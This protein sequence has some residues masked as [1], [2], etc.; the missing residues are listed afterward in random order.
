MGTSVKYRLRARTTRIIVH[1]SHTHLPWGPAQIDED[2]QKLGLVTVG[3]HFVLPREGG[4]V[5]YRPVDCI[6]AHTP[7]HNDDSIGVCWEGGR[8][9]R[10]NACPN[11]TFH[12]RKALIHL[13]A[14]L[15]DLHGKTLRVVGHS[16]VQRFKS[17]TAPQC[18]QMDMDLL[19]RDIADY[20]KGMQYG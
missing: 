5:A 16:E 19:R 15:M 20:Q 8:D 17:L 7:G 10:G 4:L 9:A 6:G 3:Y 11:I 14:D 1:D 13:C 18:P 2:T 12:Q